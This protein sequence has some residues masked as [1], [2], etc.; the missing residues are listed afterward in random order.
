MLQEENRRLQSAE[1]RCAEMAKVNRRLREDV[2]L[3][4]AEAEG[5]SAILRP[6]YSVLRRRSLT[7]HT[8]YRG[9]SLMVLVVERYI[10]LG[11]GWQCDQ[12]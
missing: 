10:L 8:K 11:R 12:V 1:G 7:W 4:K 6:N 5:V 3:V 9:L 2:A